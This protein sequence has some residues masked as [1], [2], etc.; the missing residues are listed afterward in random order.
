MCCDKKNSCGKKDQCEFHSLTK[1]IMKL[2][3][4]RNELYEK[5]MK[6]CKTNEY[7]SLCLCFNP[8]YTIPTDGGKVSNLCKYC[9]E[10]V[11]NVKCPK[12]SSYEYECP[13]CGETDGIY[14]IKGI[15]NNLCSDCMNEIN[16]L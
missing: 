9:V 13:V 4:E 5:N 8:K 2:Q 7:C 14:I 3:L 1:E 11:K 12:K 16:K 10:K 15:T 6:K